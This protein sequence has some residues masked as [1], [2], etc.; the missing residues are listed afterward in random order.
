[1]D[2]D[3]AAPAQARRRLGTSQFDYSS[4]KLK[5][6]VCVYKVTFPFLHF[7]FVRASGLSLRL[8][9]IEMPANAIKAFKCFYIWRKIYLTLLWR[10][11][12]QSGFDVLITDSPAR[13]TF[14]DHDWKP[15]FGGQNKYGRLLFVCKIHN[16]LQS[17][18]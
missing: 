14:K 3:P 12:Y 8:F 2:A 18:S 16:L 5:W 9:L 7:Y 4:I 1:M 6:L 15:L 17:C 13:Y 11:D 10:I